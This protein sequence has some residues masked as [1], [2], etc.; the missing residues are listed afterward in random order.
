MAK[1]LDILQQSNN[2]LYSNLCTIKKNA[3][4]ILSRISAV[5]PEYTDHDI[6]HS[7]MVIDN[8][9][10]LIHDDLKAKLNP[11]EL[12]V[13]AS[14]AYLHDVGMAGFPEIING[15]FKGDFEDFKTNEKLNPKTLPVHTDEEILKDFIRKNHH[16]ISEEFVSKNHRDLQ[17]IDSNLVFFIKKICRGHRQSDFS[18]KRIFPD[19]DGINGTPI[20]LPLLCALL[21]LGDELD[22]TYKRTPLII[23]NTMRPSKEISQ[24]EWLKSLIVN[25]VHHDPNDSTQLL[26]IAKFRSDVGDIDEKLKYQIVMALYLLQQKIQKMLRELPRYVHA[27]FREDNNDLKLPKTNYVSIEGMYI[28]EYINENYP[29]LKGYII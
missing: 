22:V 11:Y 20:N 27:P 24:K 18:D 17:I 3:T 23:W 1:L 28:D 16:L 9:D 10:K 13:L 14:G 26:I 29:K 12:Y 7:N 6:H 19:N 25:S 15:K 21:E 2:D 5:F 4:P 8:L